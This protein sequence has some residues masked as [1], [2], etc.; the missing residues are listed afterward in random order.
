MK[1]ITFFI[2]AF[3]I[4]TALL[5]QQKPVFGLK[6]GLN[7]SKWKVDNQNN[8]ALGTLTGFHLGG[9]AHFHLSDQIAIQPELQYSTQGAED[10]SSGNDVEFRTG[11]IN[12]PIM[13]QYMFDNGFRIEAGPQVGFLVSAEDKLPNGDELDSKSEYKKTDFSLGVGLNYLTYSGFGV[14]GRYNFGLSNINDTRSNDTYN[15]VL[16]LSVFY[17]FDKNH[18]AK[19]R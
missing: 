15:R 2:A 7:L 6:A 10:N 14:G 11:N 19:S 3:F 1:K 16:Q 5:A 13:F 18:K 8:D 9:L 12:I 4:S 17:M